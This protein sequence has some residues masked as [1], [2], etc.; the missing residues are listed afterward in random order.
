MFPFGRTRKSTT[1]PATPAG[2]RRWRLSRRSSPRFR[3]LFLEGLEGRWLLSA[4]PLDLVLIS[5][6]VTQAEQIRVA[7]AK[8]T[9]ALIYHT[10]TMTAEGLVDL[11]ASVSAAN[12]GAPIAHLGI[13]AHGHAGG[14]DLGKDGGLSLASLPRQIVA[15]DRL[16]AELTTDA[17]LD[18]YACSVAAGDAGKAF[19]DTVASLT[20]ATVY[21]S[22]NPIG[23]VPGADFVWEYR[24]GGPADGKNLFTVQQL[25]SIP[26]LLLLSAPALVSPGTSTSPGQE[27]TGTPQTFQWNQVTGATS[28]LLNVR[29]VTTNQ[30]NNYT[31]PNGTTT[32]YPLVGFTPGHVYKWNMYAYAGATPS[33]LSGS[34]YFTVAPSSPVLVSPGT[35]SSP[36]QELTGTSQTFQWNQVAG[37]TSY[38]LNVRDVTTNVLNNYTIQNGATTGY[39]LSGLIQGH[40]YRWN[41]YAFADSTRSPVSDTLYFTLR[42]ADST[43]PTINISSP[44]GGQTVNTSPITVS[45]SATDEGGAG[46]SHVILVNQANGTSADAPLS[47]NSAPFSFSGIALAQGQNLIGIRAYDNAGNPSNVVTVSVIC[48]TTPPMATISSPSDGQNASTSSITVNGWASDDGGAGLSHVIVVNQRTGTSAN[49]PLSGNSAPFSFSGLALAQGTNLI[50]VRAYD[51]ANNPSMAATVTITYV[52][53]EATPPTVQSPGTDQFPGQTLTTLQPTFQWQAVAGADQYGLYIRQMGDDGTPGTIVFDSQQQGIT[54]PGSA[55][56]YALP[57]GFLQYGGHY[58]W[59]MRTETTGA[60]GTTYSARLYF[61]VAATAP[62]ISGVSPT[63]M[64]ASNNVQAIRVYGSGFDTTASHLL[65]TDPLGYPYTSANHPWYETRISS[66]EFDYSINNS[67]AAGTWWVQVQNPNGQVSNLASFTVTTAISSTPVLSYDPPVWNATEPVGAAVN[68]HWTTSAGTPPPTYDLYRNGNL[69]SAYTANLTQTSY[70]DNAGLLPGLTYSYYVVAHN[71]AG[72]ITSN[73]VSMIIPVDLGSTAPPAPTGLTASATSD[74]SIHLDW[75]PVS[76][77]GLTY[78]VYRSP[79]PNGPWL[80][81]QV[82]VV[83]SSF[84]DNSAEPSSSYYYVVQATNAGGP[85]DLSQPATVHT[86]TRLKP[87]TPTNL[88]AIANPNTDQILV[89]WT[90]VISNGQYVLQRETAFNGNW[91]TIQVLNAGQTAYLDTIDSPSTSSAAYTY[92]IFSRANGLTSDSLESTAVSFSIAVNRTNVSTADLPSTSPVSYD[93]IAQIYRFALPLSVWIPVTTSLTTIDWSL[94]TIILTHGWDTPFDK[95]FDNY[96]ED[97]ALRFARAHPFDYSNYNILA[98]DWTSK[99]DPTLGSNPNGQTDA[100]VNLATNGLKKWLEDAKESAENGINAAKPLGKKL[101][102]GGIAPANVMLIGHSNGAGFMASLADELYATTGSKVRE[103]VALDAPV[104]TQSYWAVQNAAHVVDRIDNYFAST[105]PETPWDVRDALAGLDLG[106]PMIDSPGNITNFAIACEGSSLLK[107]GSGDVAH[108]VVPIK[109]ATTVA[110]ADWGF[111]ASGFMNDRSSKFEGKAFWGQTATGSFE[112]TTPLPQDELA[113]R[114]DLAYLWCGTYDAVL[115]YTPNSRQLMLTVEGLNWWSGGFE[116]RATIIVRSGEKL[117]ALK[118][119]VKG[120]TERLKDFVITNTNYFVSGLHATLEERLDGI[121][122]WLSHSAE[123]PTFASVPIDVPDDAAALYFDLTVTATDA[124]RDDLLLVSIGDSVVGQVDL[125]SVQRSGTQSIDFGIG[126]YAGLRNQSLTFYMPSDGPSVARF[127]VGNISVGSL[128]VDSAP[129]VSD[130][131]KSV[132]VGGEVTFTGADFCEAFADTDGD[133]MRAVMITSLP[134]YGVLSLDGAMVTLHQEIPA[135]E[136]RGLYYTPSISVNGVDSFGWNASDGSLFGVVAA[137]V[138]LSVQTGIVD[139][140]PPSPDPSTWATGPFATGSGSIRMVAAAASDPSGV[141]YFFHETTGHAGGNDSGWQD[142]RTYE[143]VGLLASTTY[144]YQVKT[145][146][147]SANRNEGGYSPVESA[148]T[149]AI[150]DVEAPI[151]NPS[152]WEVLPYATSATS[153]RMAATTASDPSGVEYDFDCLMPGGHDSGWQDSPTYEDGGLSSGT[154]YAYRVRTRDKSSS[155]NTGDYSAQMSATTSAL[156]D[157]MV[158]GFGVQQAVAQG[159]QLGMYMRASNFGAAAQTADWAAEFYLSSDQTITPAL[160][161]LLG[162]VTQSTDLPPGSDQTIPDTGWWYYTVPLSLAAGEYFFGVRLTSSGEESDLSNNIGGSPVPWVTVLPAPVLNIGTPAPIAEGDSGSK[163][164]TFPVTLSAASSQTVTVNYATANGTAT[165]GSDY[166]ATSG[167]L[168]FAPYQTSQQINVSVLGDYAIEGDETFTVSLSAATNATI[169]TA[170]AMGTIQNDDVAGTLVLSSA[171]YSVNENGG[172]MTVV[173]VRSGGLASGVGVNY[174]TSS[175]TAMAGSDFTATSGTLTF[176]GGE[177]S[178]TFTIPI[179]NDVLVEGNETFSVALSNASGGALIGTPSSAVITIVE[180][181][182]PQ[183][184][185]GTPEPIVEGDSGSKTLTFTVTLSAASSQL[186]TVSYATANG[187]A[188]AGSDYLPGSGTLTWAPGETSAKTISVTVNGD[189]NVEPDETFYVNLLSVSNAVIST[190]QGVGTIQN[191]DVPLP[192]LIVGGW[193][194]WNTVMQGGQMGVNARASNFGTA[195]QTADWTVEFYLSPDQTITPELDY[196]LGAV[197]R[198][199]DI[200]AGVWEDVPSTGYVYFPIPLS[201]APGKYYLGVRL[202]SSGVESDIS[203]NTSVESLAGVTVLPAPVLNIGTPALIAEGDS[204]SKTLTFPVTLSAASSQTVTVNYVTANGTATAGSDYTATSG[205]LTFAPY[206][207]S[208]QINVSVLGDYAIEGDETI[209]VSLSAATNATI[210]TAAAM[211]TIQNDDVAGTLVLSSATYSVNENGGAMTVVVVRSGGLASGVGVNYATSSGTAMAGSDFTATSGTLTFGGGETSK[212]FTIPIT[213]D[214]LVEGNETFSVALSNASGGALIGT[215]SSAVITIVEDDLPQVSIGTPEPIVEG[216]SGSKTLTFTVTLSAASSQL[217]TVS[218]ATANGTATA[219]SDYLPGSGTL[220]WAPGETSAKTI[221]VTVNGDRNVEPDETFYVNLLSVS[222]AVI[223]TGQG[224]GTIQNDDVPLPDLI[225]GGWGYWNTVMQGGQMGVNARASNFGTAGQTADWTVEFYLSPDQTITPELDYLLGA[226]SRSTDIAAGVWEDVPS[227]GYVYFPIPLSVAPGKYYLGVRLVSSGVES[228]I[229]NNT[230]VE[231]LAGV[232]VLPAPVLNIGTP[233]LIAEG[234]SGSKTLTFPVTLSA[235]SSQTV[236]VNYVT[237]NGT[238]T[239]GSDYIPTVGTLTWTP[240]DTSTKTISVTVNG[241]RIV[242]PDETFY[243]NLLNPTNATISTGQGVGTVRNDDVPLP[244]LLATMWGSDTAVM[245]GSLFGLKMQA[246]NFGTAAQT[247]DWLVEFYLS[248]DETISPASDY[249]LGSVSRSTD[250]APGEHEDVPQTGWDY[251]PVPLTVSPGTYSFGVRLDSSGVESDIANNTR[252]SSNVVTVLPAPVLNIGTPAPIA[253]GDSGSKTL[254]FPVTLSAASSQTVTVNYV[255]ANG[256]ATAGSD[257]TATSGTLTFAPYQTSQQI[258]VSVLGDYAIEGDET[259]TVSLSAATNATIG[260]AAAMGTIQNDDVAGTLVLSSATYSVNENGGA[261]T[262]VVVRSGGLASGVGVNY[263]TSSGTA[264]AGSDFTATSGTLTFGGG[265]T[266]KTFTIPITNDVLVEGNETFSVALSNASGG[267]LIGTP[268]SAV[269]TIVEDDLPQV[270]IG[271]PEPIVEG[272]SGSKTLTFTVTLSAASSQLVTVSYATANGTAT[273]GSDYLPG[274]GTLTWAPGET[275]AK[276]ISVTVNGDR[277]VEPDET[278]YVNLLSVSNAVIS[279]GQG[280]GT[281]QNDDV[282]LPDLIVGGWGYWNTV[283]QGGQMGVN[284]RASNFGTAGQTADWTVEFYLSPDQTITPELDY[285]LG[286]VSRS[287]DIAAGVWE[288]VPSTGYVYF[289]IPLSVAPGKYYLGVRLVSSGV[290]SDISNNTS[291]ESLAGVTVLPAPVLNIGTPALI[292][293]GDSGSKTLTFPVTLSAASSQTVTVNYVT[294]NGTATAGSDYTATSGTLTFAPYQTS[295]QINVSVLGDYAIEGDETITV[296]LSAATNATIGTAAAMGTIQNDDV[297]GT[298][299]LSSATYSVNENGGAMTVVVVRSGGLASG[300]GV[301]YATSSGTAMAGSDFTATSG[302]LTFGGGETSKTFTIPITNDV[303]VEGNETF[304]VA[305]SNASGGALIGTP[306]SAVITIVEDDLPQVSI[307]TPEPIVEGDSGSKTLTFTVTLSAASSQL[308][309]VSYATAN[310]TATAGS[311]YLPGSGTLT[312]APGE[313]SAKTISVT[314]NGDRNVEPDETFY[315]N[316][317]SVSNAVIST[318]QG[319]GTIQNDDVPLPDLIVGGWGYWNTVM[320]GG[321]MGVNARASN[322]G[323]A[324]QTADWTVEFYLS[325]D[326][327]ITP[328]LDYLLGAVSRSTDIAAGVWEDVPSTGY[329]YFPIPLSVAPGKYYLGVRLVSSGVESD[330][331]NNTSVESLAGVT[332]LPAPVLNIGTPALIAEGDSGSKTLT[333]PVT[334][335]AASSQTVTVNYVTANGTATAGSDYI[336]TVGTLTWTPGDTSTKTISVTVNGDRIVEPDETFYVNLLNPTNATIST[337]QGVGT[338]RNDDVPLPDLLATMW[339]S[340]TAVMQGSLFGL[341]MQASNFGTAAQTADWLVEFYLSSDETISPASDYLLGSVSRSTDIA[342]GEHEDVPQTGWDYFPVPLTVSPGTYSFGVRLDS[343]GVESDIANNTRI[344]SNVVTVLPAPVL[345]IG[346]PAPIAEGDSGSKTLTFPVTLSAASSQTVTVNYATAN[347]TAT[348]G[349]D[350]T[351]TSGTLTF[352]PYQTSQQINVSVLGDYAIEGD[353]TFTVSLSAATNATIGTAAAT[354]TIRDDDGAVDTLPPVVTVTSLVTRNNRPT[355]TG[356][357]SDA[358]PSSGLAGVTVVVN[359]QTL[360]AAIS[361]TTWSATV[362]TALG[363]GVYNVTATATDGAGN[364]GS[365]WSSDELT[366]ESAEPGAPTSVSASDDSFTDR[367]RVTWNTPPGMAIGVVKTVMLKDWDSFDFS[368][369]T[370]GYCVGGDFYYGGSPAEFLANNVGQRGVVD[371]GAI[372]LRS[373][374]QIPSSGFTQFGVNAVVGH[375]YVSL[376]QEGEEGNYIFFEVTGIDAS[377]ATIEWAYGSNPPGMATTIVKTVTLKDGEGYD[378]STET[379]GNVGV[380]DFY[381]GGSP[382][383]FWANNLG[384]RGVVDVGAMRLRSVDQIPSSGFT[385]FGVNAVVGHS[386]VSLAQEGEEGSYLFFE[387][388]GMNASGVTIDWVY[389]SSPPSQTIVDYEVWRNVNN[390]STTASRISGTDVNG[391]SY[392]DAT[393]AAGTQY[394]YWVKAKN[395]VGASGFSGSD[396]GRRSPQADTLPPAVTVTSLVTRNN[397][398]TLT[399]TVSDAA[400]SSGLAGVTVVVNGQ[401]L[402]AAISGT[403]WSA[404]VGTALADGVYNVTATAWDGAGNSASDATS[405]ELIVDTLPPTVTVTSLVTRNNRPTLTGTVSEWIPSSGLSGVTVAVNGQT[406]TATVS[407]SV[408][409]A[410]VATALPEGTYE[411]TATATDGAGNSGS[412]WSSDEL[413]VESAEPG[414]PTSVSASDDS[415]TDRVRVTW[416]TPPGMAISVVKTVTLKDG[417]SFDFSTETKG[418]C[419][420]G[421]LFYGGTLPKFWAAN[422]GQRGVVDL[423]AI[424]L[425][426]LDQMPSSG[427][428]RFG[429]NAVVGHS[430]VSLAQEGE[431]GNYIFFEITGIDASGA[432][433]EWAYG[434]NPPGMATTIVKTV[435]LKDGEGYDSSTETKGNVGVGDFYYGG[436]PANFWANNLGQRGVVDVGAMRLRSV[437]QIPSSGF[438]RFGVNAVVGHS[439]VS[440]A[441]EGEE[442]S[443]LFF[444]VTGMNASGVTIDWV[445]GS[446]PP[447]QTIVDY[448]VWRNVNNDSTTASRISG[449]DVNGLSYDDAT[450]AAGTQYWYWVKA[451]NAVGASGFSGSDLGRRSPQADTLPPAVTVTSLVTRNNQP[452]LTGTVSDAAP[453]SG[454][455]GVTVVVNGQTL[456]AAISGTTWSATVGTALADGVYNVTATAWDGAGNSASDATSNELIVDTLPPTVTVTSLVTRNNRPTLTGT[457]SEWI[458]SSGLSGV[459]VAVNGQTLTATVSG[460]VW[461]ASV[462]TAL[463]EGTYEVTAT[464]TDGA[465]NSGSDWSSDELTVESAEP[466]APTS[467]SASDDSFTDRV[468]VTWNTPPGMAISVV[469]TVTLKDG[470][471]FDFSTETKGSCVGGDLFYGGTLPKFWA[472]NLGQRG[473]VDLGAIRLRSLDQMP[474]SGFTRFGVNAVVGHSYVSLAQEGEEGNYIFFEITGIDASGATIEWAYGSNPPGMATTIVKTVTLKDGEGYDSSTET[475]GNV[476]VGDFYYG[477]SPA[478]FWANNLGQRGVVDVGA[479]R[480]RSVD[481]IP[482]S[483]FTRFGVNAVVGHSYVSLAQEG[484][485][486]SYLF[487]EVTGMN[488]SGVT[489]DW[490]YGS[491]P[492]SQTIVDYEVWRNVNNDSTTASRISGTDVNGLSYDDATAAAGTQYWYWVK[493]KNAVGASGFSGSDLG[494]RSPQADTQPPTV[495]VTSLVTRNNQPTLTGTVSDAAPSSGL[496]GVTV[497]VNGQTLTATISGTSWSATVRTA[498]ADGVYNVTA[499]ARDGTGN[500]AS[501]ATSNELIVDTTAPAPVI[502]GPASPTKADPFQV[503]ITFGEVVT[504]FVLGDLMATG[505]TVTGLIDNGGGN[506]TGTIDALADGLVSVTVGPGKAADLAGNVNAPSNVL[507]LMVNT[508]APAA[509]ADAIAVSEG[510]TATGLVGGATSVLTNDTDADLPNDTLTVDTAPVVLPQHGT[511][512]LR[513]DGTFQYVHDGSENFTDSFTYQ[514]SDAVGH[515]AQAVVAIT[516]T[517]ANDNPPVFTSSATPSVPENT[518]AVVTLMATDADLPAQT[519]IFSVTGGADHSTFQIVGGQL[520]FKAAPD[521][522]AP[523]DANVD[524]RYVVEVTVTDSGSPALSTMQTLTVTVTS[525]N[526]NPPVFTSSATPSVPENTTAVVTL[527]ATDADL[528]A[529]TVIFSVTGGADQSTFQIVG[530]QLQFKAAPD[531]EAPTDANVDNRYVV[532]VMATDS[533][534][535]ALSTMQTLTVT[536]TSANDNPPVFTS[537]ATPSVPENTTAVVTLMATDADLPAQTVIFSVTGGADQSTFQIVGGQ[538]QFKA[539]PD[540]EA[541]TDANVDNRYVVEVTVTDNGSPALS[542]MQTLTVTVTSANDNP[543]VFT[544]SATPSVPENTTAVVTLMATD[545]DLPA[546]TVIFSVTGGA[547]QSTF[548][549]VGGQLQFKAAPDYEAPTDANVDNRYVVE[550]TATDSGS[551]AL[552]TVQTLTVTVTSAN[553]NPPVFTSSATPSVPENTTAVVTLMATDA[554]LPAQTVIFSVTGGADQSTFQIVGGQLQFK[555]APDYEA[556]TDANVDNRYVVEVTVTDSGSPALSTM[557]TLTVTVTSANDNPPVFTSSATPSVP[558]NTTAVV[559]LMATD[560]DLPAQTVIFSVTGGADQSTFQIVGGQLQ[561]KAAPDYEAPTDANVDNRYVVEVMATDSGS[562]ALSTMQTLTVTVTSANDNPPVFTS[563]AT[564]SVPE[565]T[566]AVV[567]LMATDADLPAQTVIFSVTGGADQSTFQIVG[568]QLQFKAAPDYEAPTDANVDNRYVVE[569]TVTDS[570][571]PALSTMQTLTV[572]VTSANDNPPVFTSSATPSVPENTTAVVTLMATDADLP[573]QTVIFSVTGGADQ[574]TFQIVGGQLQFKAAPDYEAPTDANVDNRYVVEVTATDSGS[575]ALSTVQTL[576]VTVTSANDNPPVFTS[577]A[578][579]SVPENTTAVVTLMATDADLPAQTVIFSVTG[580]ADQST[581][582]IVGGQL[583]FKAAPDYEAPTDANVDNR[584]VVEVTVTDSGSPALSTMQTLTVTVTSA[585][586]NPPVF[587]SSATPSVPENTTAV[588][589]LMATDAD[590]PAQ[591]VIFSVTGGADQSTFQIVGGQLQFKAAPDYEAPTDANVD[592]RYVVEVM[593]TDSG[594]PALST[595]QTLTVTVTSAN[596]NPPVFTSSATPSVP[597]NTTAVVTL[598]ATDA[599]LPAQT[600]IFSVTGGADQSTFQI[601]GGQLQFKAAPDYEAPTDANVDNRYVVE[602]TVTDSGSPALSTMQTLTVTVTSAN[603]NPPVFTSSATPSVPE[604]TTAVVTLM[605]TDADLPAQTVIFSVTGGADQSTFQIVGGQLQF[606]AAPDYEAPTDANVD[607]RYVVEVTATDS[608]SPALSTM[609]TLTV[610]VTSA[611]DNPP[612]LEPIGSRSVTRGHLLAFTAT[613]TDSDLPPD[614]LMYSLDAESM[615]LGMTIDS[616]TGVF[617]W[618]PAASQS[619]VKYHVTVTVADNG[620]PPLSDSDAFTIVVVGSTWQ[621]PHHY[622]DTNDDGRITPIDVLILIND[623]NV[624]GSRDLT[625]GWPPTPAPPPFLDPSGDGRISPLD[626]LFVINDI[627]ANDSRPIPSALG[628]E[629]ESTEQVGPY[630]PIAV[631]DRDAA[632]RVLSADAIN[633]PWEGWLPSSIAQSVADVQPTERPIAFE[634]SVA[635]SQ[636]RL[637]DAYHQRPLGATASGDPDSPNDRSPISVAEG[638][639]QGSVALEEILPDIAEDVFH[640]WHLRAISNSIFR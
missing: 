17:R 528:P 606:K 534:S 449:T 74:T 21:A 524:N 304:S 329:V 426:S 129:S 448:E 408:W 487:F 569:V 209:T 588:V 296:S 422:L 330:I 220:T 601:V 623:L 615:G 396:L 542:T 123:S 473:V 24:T 236:T 357:V 240:G 145:R 313:T 268:S 301:N 339:G 206:Q 488:A 18:L 477:G 335:S 395:A 384:Q 328:E 124:G 225:V 105:N 413:T 434:S 557:Q 110:A 34:L 471:S 187:T 167:T 589:T 425:R 3:R 369:E 162:S 392:D 495:T 38:Q 201:V 190:G 204:G 599:D 507:T 25:E 255:T 92:R 602:V 226:V 176:G 197:S 299:V 10:D 491:S 562:P 604:N 465:G 537:S 347:G 94:K 482:S 69:L 158:T 474:S 200:A 616:A 66:T 185:I 212:T 635:A 574:S 436:S 33:P 454:L 530:G 121:G 614:T 331:S 4:R 497:V 8:D 250:I 559:T 372:R 432:T 274:S 382:A 218:Y 519:V 286:A 403:T 183:V 163:T 168:T 310:G 555:A 246:S 88:T 311:D 259:I 265:E 338:V 500:S 134:Q 269:I 126:Q 520:Q 31:I 461:N 19:V 56:S 23:N 75:I 195:G 613:A 355:L 263:A 205:T 381:Y 394:W 498:L 554:D 297:A 48:D 182:L 475:K 144:S 136:L 241:D 122:S 67:S 278:F 49:V 457:V 373:L 258:N 193:G 283:M 159:G 181:D 621:N 345:N 478:N 196:L 207:T 636:R 400:P 637:R 202:V 113:L 288:D 489:I 556:P 217:V 611:N 390:D 359:G 622:F 173:V 322:F 505:G 172:A 160:D 32:T 558:E 547:D 518:T 306:S 442:G 300:V 115:E 351:A 568:G 368:T 593:A 36:G 7:A 352:A 420:G 596:D 135:A 186:V 326:Q 9:I 598:M 620:T 336:P 486:G 55:N 603:D 127:V 494:R 81:I 320:Q 361:G 533:G 108:I 553:D 327:T 153:I 579:P 30:L 141:E 149:P 289:P 334:L 317:L 414:A 463:P 525:A 405:N 631:S 427:F 51:N 14:I 607:N 155:Q 406:L 90:D 107:E 415:F 358:A 443:Y 303:L 79:F 178:K 540:Y 287:T 284:A 504:G 548:Q 485:E 156:P 215:P 565:N 550:V 585:N 586:D 541:P 247:A 342:P 375:S 251:F 437:D 399:G 551:P 401:T 503:V 222:N 248:S 337:G 385:R 417:D 101:A 104:E 171:T 532:E 16:R 199:T 367:V 154:T 573:A 411:V 214:V 63:S 85:S 581:F 44:S 628:G 572:T 349:S 567:T 203:N 456:T 245:Q 526:D 6:S 640:G 60:W 97:F 275:S 208:Q 343:S 224:V 267:A 229:S 223:S 323:T 610:T 179:T 100:V 125:A 429:V 370:K 501:D 114:N 272:D 594:S 397:Q 374:D 175:G 87:P 545:A 295:Q 276:T 169:G 257:Y 71:A 314:V 404:T 305:L 147:K 53:A 174:A 116:W 166:T 106:A 624:R 626:V 467:V 50:G 423:G 307:G 70:R 82:N 68:L 502:N 138:I 453:S 409:N 492:P 137:S 37:A 583:Q 340:D 165:A 184:S 312:W 280:V 468:R 277:N 2:V 371:L 118:Q 451:K 546:Q 177:T 86:P 180:D 522:E 515:T 238:A 131:S 62:S 543:P 510:G 45:G 43:P 111:A 387:V 22:D 378:S 402:T 566:T 462:A 517:P 233:A 249:L 28:Y 239:A 428:T 128:A 458:P 560:A 416:N 333:F 348:A 264:M 27:L 412:D 539:A 325:P 634:A 221:S 146:D 490:V 152:R 58:R 619:L 511:L 632:G 630:H 512:A 96:I 192:D 11:V 46:L 227:T 237:A 605:A 117:Q 549:I 260:T 324:G 119:Y 629:G 362:G 476:G 506:Y 198:S 157:L 232:T 84:D 407:G 600:V 388:T 279:T 293:E 64:P 15:L 78:L 1:S 363:E 41:M 132:I 625:T 424:R 592:N 435:T 95:P 170:A 531:Y 61:A 164:L 433:I 73:T 194:Y 597:E 354:G 633:R 309:T 421:D 139:Q 459:T 523:T 508:I 480:L 445:Y 481:Q 561:F 452:T 587:T 39:P 89:T 54:I 564:P 5:D 302:T 499:T 285:L 493:A 366:V 151:P 77:P 188:T 191:D 234:D 294:A 112:P 582:Q 189:R 483:G 213:N 469:K 98:V 161:Y 143:D 271:T 527:M 376:A 444:E 398:P 242:E 341:K 290:E 321:Q 627:N 231:S 91:M 460:S 140:Q 638:M 513:A 446:S 228:D 584:Y 365:D 148:S 47:G 496:S 393:A 291:V 216:D 466:G 273:A 470:D 509:V 455:A 319:V 244:D 450:A 57:T 318:G 266:S 538:L 254:T 377:G 80:P 577:S 578:T 150:G 142:S 130:I 575:P 419:V 72:G 99:T 332:V 447:S 552:S 83:K 243:V 418:S 410:S 12:D 591:T 298:L 516:V 211:G 281:I 484:E 262:V 535:P 389:G 472:A 29:D 20:G 40:A 521:Y 441:Q 464:A 612:V 576:T 256:T 261:M 431:E 383:S 356:T 76:A 571:S 609:Q 570:G 350:Y 391:L 617:S 595:M 360:T 353:E 120:S 380:G 438:T 308:V 440:L 109:Y 65:F 544:S 102:I 536:V 103:L 316:L 364:S 439:Y 514:V 608:G 618:T 270:S 379:K 133:P 292:A 386:Y 93:G 35:S 26:R 430:Y 344:S 315:V 252:I 42:L 210:G 230:S 479:M 346:T 563:S 235:A 282:P 253:E 52:V 219:G 529:Q 590:L 639:Q 59:N 13:V 580:G